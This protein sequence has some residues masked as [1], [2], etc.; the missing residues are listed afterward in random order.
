MTTL[1]PKDAARLLEISEY[2]ATHDK[3]GAWRKGS[4]GCHRYTTKDRD[5]F[6]AMCMRPDGHAGACD[7]QAAMKRINAGDDV[8]FLLRVVSGL[9]G[10]K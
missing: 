5:G 2:Y 10:E 1:D 6:T 7:G 8:V 4:K 9:L 3:R